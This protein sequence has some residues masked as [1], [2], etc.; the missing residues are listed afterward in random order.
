MNGRLENKNRVTEISLLS[1]RS[2]TPNHTSHTPRQKSTLCF[3]VRRRSFRR[4][5]TDVA[6]VRLLLQRRYLTLKPRVTRKGSSHENKT[7]SPMNVVVPLGRLAYVPGSSGKPLQVTAVLGRPVLFWLLDSLQLDYERDTVWIVLSAHDEATYQIFDSLSAEYRTLT[8]D[9]RLRLIP[10]YFKTRG[11]VE[12]LHV[13]LQYMEETDLQKTTLCVNADMIFNPSVSV[14]SRSISSN[15]VACFT[16]STS[17]VSPSEVKSLTQDYEWCYCKLQHDVAHDAALSSPK[18]SSSEHLPQYQI[19]E[20]TFGCR[21][22]TVMVGAYVFGSAALLSSIISQVLQSSSPSISKRLGF[23]DLVQAGVDLLQ[24]DCIGIFIPG[25]SVTPLKCGEHVQRLIDSTARQLRSCT[26]V[27]GKSTR[28]LFQ[29]YGGILSDHNKPRKQVIDAVRQLKE[30]GHHITV[31]SSRG[32]SA[33]A[34]KTLIEQLDKF[35]IQYDEIELHDDDKDYTVIVGSYV[36][37][38]RGDLNTSLG[39]PGEPHSLDVVQPRHFNQLK[40]TNETVTKKSAVETLEGEAFYYE[41]IP[42]NLQ[43]LFPALL[44]KEIKADGEL[45][46]TISKVEGVTF[47]QLLVNRCINESTLRSLLSAMMALHSYQGDANTSEPHGTNYYEN[48][49]AKV[50]R[51]YSLHRSLYDRI[52]KSHADVDADFIINSITSA[53]D[54]YEQ[55]NRADVRRFIHGD[56]VFSNC[57][58]S[59]AGETRLIDM[60]GKLGHVLTTTGDCTYDLAKMLQSLFGYDHVLLDVSMDEFDSIL[61]QRLR[62]CFQEHVTRHYPHVS[63]HDIQLITASLFVSLIPLH[64]NFSHQLQFWRM[65][66]H[67]YECWKEDSNC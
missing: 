62:T 8:T 56:P 30:L 31:S 26:V 24:S 52:T 35:D 53:L 47:S 41:N 63:W 64:D 14:A 6:F 67:V 16:A 13:A 22:E 21:T 18:L 45:C 65:G 7:S 29:M 11:V 12:T 61:L 33:S 38:A 37:D 36:C 19:K 57:L 3:N 50:R 42:K 55:N 54:Q 20:V 2:V 59:A 46:I 34:V 49:S 32:R 27:A 58:L 10:L 28:Y 40:F 5:K 17:D 66:M 23:P 25:K 44:S 15:S 43:H 51:R 4:Q 48:Y 60:N 9:R 1:R 39:L